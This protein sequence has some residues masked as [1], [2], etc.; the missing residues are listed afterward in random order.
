MRKIKQPTFDEA[1]EYLLE[2]YGS[3]NAASKV[4]GMSP[5]NLRRVMSDKD[6]AQIGRTREWV[7]L[8]VWQE[9]MDGDGA[10]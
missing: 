2:K 8:K 7:C 9:Q 5:H 6:M 10:A 1:K 3:W 4:I